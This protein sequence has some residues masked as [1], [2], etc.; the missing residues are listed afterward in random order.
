MI[1]RGWSL[2][3][4]FDMGR[5]KELVAF[6]G[7]GGKTSLMFALAEALPG[8]TV[9]TTTTRIFAAQMKLAPAT[10]SAGDLS[11]LGDHLD[12]QGRCLVIGRV[13][14]EKASGV[15]PE[16]PQELLARPDVDYVLVE[17]DGSRMRPIKAPAEHEP[18]IPPGTTLLV[19]VAGMDA[20]NGPLDAVAHRPERVRALLRD[21]EA[22]APLLTPD[23][24]LTVA[25]LAALL[26]HPQGGLKSAPP[27]ARRV[28]FIN[29]VET[30]AQLELAGEAGR[31]VLEASPEVARVVIGATRTA[32]P[33]RGVW[34]R[35]GG[36]VLAAGQSARMG[37]NKLLLP[38]GEATVIEQTVRAARSTDLSGIIA[39][40]G[41]DAPQVSRLPGLAGATIVH[42]ARYEQGMLSSVQTAIRLAPPEWA[43][44]VVLLGDQPMVGPAIINQILAAYARRP[45]GLVVPR[46]AGRRGNPV[47]IDRRYFGELLAL[48]PEAAPR[49]LL[50]RHPDDIY[51]LDIADG[52]ILHDLD[53]PEDYDRWRPASS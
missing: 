14:G 34:R 31:S 23:D 28:P 35:V 17:A 10:I 8:R 12:R 41:H 30:A 27:G 44:A 36:I 4:A 21:L 3:A 37:R 24:R 2:P 50:E 26:I 22:T 19:P 20:L 40:T 32:E 29:K 51:W 1:P 47:L 18:V 49:A 53:V 45:A 16:L 6:V 39:V 5:P 46:Y 38:W 33:V 43:A 52:A 25:G 11:Q 15:A 42:N 9:L 13:A 48:P 7:G